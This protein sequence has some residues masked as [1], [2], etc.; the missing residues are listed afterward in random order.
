LYGTTLGEGNW[1]FGTLFKI[2]QVGGG[3]TV[4]K[5]FGAGDGRNARATVVAGIDGFLYGT[6]QNGGEFVTDNM[7]SSIPYRF[8]Q[9]K[10]G[11]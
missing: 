11:F 10:L 1:G 6:T 8:Y 7:S 2:R 4:I 5:H 3:Y 9:A